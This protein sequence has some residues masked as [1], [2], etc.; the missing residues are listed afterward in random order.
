MEVS[1][2]AD[3][4]C[5]PSRLGTPN[6]AKKK[7]LPAL[8]MDFQKNANN[9]ETSIYKVLLHENMKN[10]NLALFGLLIQKMGILRF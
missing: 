1:E 5:Y 9:T 6:L 10:M 7:P 4:H 2:L 3:S 8:E